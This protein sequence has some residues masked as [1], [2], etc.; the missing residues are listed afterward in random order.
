MSGLWVQ[1]GTY[2]S[3]GGWLLAPIALVCLGIWSYFLRSRDWLARTLREGERVEEALDR[4]ELGRTAEELAG[5]LAARPGGVAAIL[6][7]AL[8]D[9]RGGAAPREA[10]AARTAEGLSWLGRDG[11]VL[12][13]LTAVAP[14][15]GLLGTVMGMIQTFDA[16]ATIGGG[17]GARVAGGIS[18]ALITTQFGLVVALPGV[19]GVARLQRMRRTIQGLLDECRSHLLQDLE[20]GGGKGGA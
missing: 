20:R 16:A 4:R 10:F 11:V 6:R 17:T 1:A 18:Q 12:G 8:E 5:G 15:L 2:W 9:I 13:A 7:L 19:F 14:L 3:A